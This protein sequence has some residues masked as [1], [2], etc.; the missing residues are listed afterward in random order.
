MENHLR[1]LSHLNYV[2]SQSLEHMILS[3]ASLKWGMGTELETI[4]P[5][6]PPMFWASGTGAAETLDAEFTLFVVQFGVMP[7]SFEIPKA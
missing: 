3:R 7:S 6:V 1:Y 2:F 4:G 5:W